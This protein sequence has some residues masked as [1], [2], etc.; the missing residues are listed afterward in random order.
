MLNFSSSLP[1]HQFS[2]QMWGFVIL[3]HF[4]FPKDFSLLLFLHLNSLIFLWAMQMSFG[5][6]VFFVCFLLKEWK[7]SAFPCSS[8]NTLGGIRTQRTH[9]PNFAYRN[10]FR[11]HCMQRKHLFSKIIYQRNQSDHQCT[12]TTGHLLE[13]RHSFVTHNPCLYQRSSREF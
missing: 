2:P 1:T 11:M 12:V 9:Y 8:Y 4:S 3:P 10:G 7:W 5:K 13:I 6:V